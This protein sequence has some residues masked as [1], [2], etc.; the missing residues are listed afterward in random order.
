MSIPIDLKPVEMT[1]DVM[2]RLERAGLIIRL[3]PRN[4][5]LPAKPGETL[6]EPIYDSSEANGPHRLITISVNKTALDEFGTHADNEEFLLIGDADMKPLYLVVALCRGNE[7]ARKIEQ[8]M[9]SHTD[10]LC[11][12]VRYND[13]EVS[14]FT[15]LREVP[16]GEAVGESDGRPA[17]FYVTEPRDLE[18]DLTDFGDYRVSISQAT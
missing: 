18:T 3:S 14:F 4:H 16:H 13:P 1:P 17:T 11:L 2:K 6:W 8:R 5:E 12:R 7:L 9:L 10:F 15:I